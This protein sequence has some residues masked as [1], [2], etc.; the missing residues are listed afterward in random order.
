[1]TLKELRKQN[2]LTQKECAAFLGVPFRTYQ[3]YESNERKAGSIKYEFMMQKLE[4]YGFIDEDHGILSLKDI[5]D[6]CEEVFAEYNVEYCYLFGSYAKGTPTENS[7]VDLL[8]STADT[9]IRFYDLVETL[10]EKL[11]KKVDVLNRDQLV[12]NDKLL[13]EILRDG[14]KIYG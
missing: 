1:M 10:R 3:N 7:D 5:K 9:G 13:D 11:R 14:V 8:V 4:K 2:N 12:G 6:K